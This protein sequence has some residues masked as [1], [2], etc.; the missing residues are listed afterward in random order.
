[1]SERKTGL[2]MD[3]AGEAVAAAAAIVKSER[4]KR[5]AVDGEGS[6][7]KGAIGSSVAF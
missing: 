2:I 3:E 5:K 1:M 4:P 7:V 6:Y